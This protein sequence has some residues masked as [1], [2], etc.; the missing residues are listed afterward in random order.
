[1]PSLPFITTFRTALVTTAL[2]LSVAALS[3]TALAADLDELVAGDVVK[4]VGDCKFTE[5]PAWHPDGYLL[6][7][8][9]PNNR[10]VRVTN[11]GTSSD[12]LT[13][14]GGANGLMCD[15]DGNV[16]AAQ[17]EAAQVGLFRTGN[18]GKGE[19]VKVLAKEYD[20]KPFNRPNDL[21]VD[22]HGGVY[23]T[24]PNYGS[25]PPDQPVEGVYYITADGKV[26]RVVDDLPRPNGVL[27]TQDGKSL[28]VANINLREII[29]Y[30]IEAPGKLSKGEVIFTGEEDADGGGPDGMSLDAKGN[31]YA[32]YKTVVVLEPDGQLIGRIEIPEKPANCAFGGDDNRT[33]YVTARTSLYSVPMKVAGIPLREVKQ[34]AAADAPQKEVETVTVKARDITLEIPKA[35]DSSPPSSNMRLAQFQIPPVEGDEEP[36]ELVIFP[37]FG[38]GVSANVQRWIGQFSGQGRQLK[39]T[40]GEAEQGKYVVVDVTG[41]Y[42]KPDGPPIL[43]RTVPTSGYRMLAVMF[44]KTGGGDYSFKLTGPEKTVGAVTDQFRQSFGGDAEK[45]K[46]YEF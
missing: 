12:W 1:M 31:I 25:D 24:D 34:Q 10:I 46:P 3:P 17:G 40:Q 7:S 2:L 9:I 27:V 19:L 23:V 43:N 28:L 37:P 39:L 11:D 29:R 14:S 5:G 20:G 30:S 26:T 22:A 44:S 8:D 15:T 32:T 18:D 6:F 33:L 16:Y 4:V 35:W 21:A 45:E 36:A 41:T 42:N 38:G 13:E